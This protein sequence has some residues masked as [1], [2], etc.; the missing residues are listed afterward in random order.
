MSTDRPPD[1]FDDV[2]GWLVPMDEGRFGLCRMLLW[3]RSDG[4]VQ[5]E[6]SVV[7]A[8]PEYTQFERSLPAEIW[9]YDRTLFAALWHAG[10]LP[11][12][13]PGENTSAPLLTASAPER[14]V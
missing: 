9:G 2:A 10:F 14:P 5:D 6:A 12:G 3:L 4:D 1:W 7:M 11:A 13:R 8:H